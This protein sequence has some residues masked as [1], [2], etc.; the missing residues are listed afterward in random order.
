ML[1]ILLCPSRLTVP[2]MVI[3][4]LAAILAKDKPGQNVRFMMFIAA[5]FYVP[6]LLH[7]IPCFLIY[8][9]FV[10]VLENQPVLRIV[11]LTFLVLI[12]FLVGSEIDG[13][14]DILLL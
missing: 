7:H 12:A 11:L 14:A 13:V 1:V 9:R 5:A 10:R 4:P 6:E 2:M 3:H 8:N